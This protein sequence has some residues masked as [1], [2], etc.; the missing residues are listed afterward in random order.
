MAIPWATPTTWV[1]ALVL[2]SQGCLLACTV[3]QAWAVLEA[4]GP[5]VE[6]PTSFLLAPKQAAKWAPRTLTL[7]RGALGVVEATLVGGRQVVTPAPAPS[8]VLGG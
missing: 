4:W 6:C 1:E 5:W 3:G 2:A 7:G 8:L